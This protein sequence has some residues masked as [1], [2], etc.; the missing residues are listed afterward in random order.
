MSFLLASA[1]RATTGARAG[2]EDA[3]RLWPAE[4]VAR[5][6]GAGGGL[7]AVL[8]DGMG[9]HTGGAVAGQ[10][11]CST[12]AEVFSAATTPYEERLQSALQASN[13]ALAKGVEKNAALKGMG[14]TLIAAW[15]D[16]VGLRWTSVGDS[17]LLLYRFPDV[18]R[19]NADHSLGSFLDEQAR[20]NRIT[21]SEAKQHHN[22][23]ALR[24]ALTGSKIDLVDLR[25]E[26]LE[27]RA[28][29]WILLAS[30]GI[31]SL[32]GDEIADL[33][34]NFRESTPDQMA[35]GLIAAV[36]KKAVA[37]QDNTTVV[38]V[39]VEE[40]P[41]ASDATTTRIVRRPGDEK[42]LRSRRIGIT[43]RSKTS[44]PRRPSAARSVRSAVWLVAAAVFFLIFAATVLLRA[45]QSTTMPAPAT[46]APPRPL[47]AAVTAPEPA[48]G[49]TPGPTG[50]DGP[51]A[52]RPP[53]A[54]PPAT[55]KAA[56][57]DAAPPVPVKPPAPQRARPQPPSAPPAAQPP[58]PSQ[59]PGAQS[60][61]VQEERDIQPSKAKQQDDRD[62][63]VRRVK[64]RERQA[65]EGLKEQPPK[66]ALKSVIKSAPIAKDV[67]KDLSR[68]AQRDSLPW[69]FGGSD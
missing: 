6:N 13:E 30:D 17:L 52:P 9:G 43:G 36:V 45:L 22:R 33:V 23:N 66:E 27:L 28:G 10:T 2:Q 26:P 44:P 63:P 18:M 11:A 12:F 60:G 65:K 56:T 35:D 61:E 40:A 55:P 29:D 50:P 14:C 37:G 47:P 54:D 51:K 46:T 48:T 1:A 59:P 19:L 5:P 21:F 16:E 67:P 31:C 3:F 42:E 39:R 62:A 57:P 58:G 69:G 53:A 4:G 25:S 32:E 20:Q 7:L 68:P 24:S 34:Y 49:D 41:D 8:A 15:M 38:A 64:R